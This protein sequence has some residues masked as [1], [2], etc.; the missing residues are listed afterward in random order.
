MDDTSDISVNIE[1][2]EICFHITYKVSTITILMDFFMLS[3]E[4][5]LAF[6][7]SIYWYILSYLQTY[8]YYLNMMII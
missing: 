6:N 3:I 2:S 1:V 4:L 8:G 5:Y 7:V